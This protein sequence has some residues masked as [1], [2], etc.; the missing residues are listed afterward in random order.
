MTRPTGQV[1]SSDLAR[2]EARARARREL[3]VDLSSRGQSSTEMYRLE[4]APKESYQLGISRGAPNRTSARRDRLGSS[5]G[6]SSPNREYFS[7][8]LTA[9][10][11]RDL[12]AKVFSR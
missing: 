10:F 5:R 4:L 2:Y 9:T 11:L 12:L 6:L 3:A 7:R 8:T 1:G